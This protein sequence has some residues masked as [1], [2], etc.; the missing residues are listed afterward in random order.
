MKMR[1]LTLKVKF[2]RQGQIFVGFLIWPLLEVDLNLRIFI[3]TLE[4]VFY[5][6]YM[7]MIRLE[8]CLYYQ[9]REFDT[10]QM[11]LGLEWLVEFLSKDGEFLQVL[12]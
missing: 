7:V 12:F 6:T 1:R 3:V 4:L 10:Y 5:T 8:W 2:T 9:V 11:G